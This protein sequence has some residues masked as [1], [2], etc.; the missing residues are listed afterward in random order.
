MKYIIDEDEMYSYYLSTDPIISFKEW[1]KDKKPVEEIAR[2]NVFPFK[3][4]YSLFDKYQ[5]KYITIYAQE[6]IVKETPEQILKL[7]KENK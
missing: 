6:S 4:M 3:N 2:G 1:V 5:D 7:I